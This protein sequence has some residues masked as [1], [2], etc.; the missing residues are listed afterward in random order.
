MITLLAVTKLTIIL[1]VITIDLVKAVAV[2]A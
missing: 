1:S 2:K